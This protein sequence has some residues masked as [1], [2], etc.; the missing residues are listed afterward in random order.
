MMNKSSNQ[1]KEI[2]ICYICGKEIFPEDEQ[3][4]VKTRRGT[5]IRFHRSCVR[6]ISD[7][8]N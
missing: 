5:E 8:S 2:Y 3:E 6:R 4:Y 1:K 7:G